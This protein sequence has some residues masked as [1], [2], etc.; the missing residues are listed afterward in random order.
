MSDTK[1][2]PKKERKKPHEM[3]K[4]TVA[5]NSS[6]STYLR[7]C[8]NIFLHLLLSRALLIYTGHT[9]FNTQTHNNTSRNRPFFSVVLDNY[10][11]LITLI[12]EAC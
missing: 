2:I 8:H 3:K 7:A 11:I 5:A 10:N 1:S 4:L 9:S 12:V 6:T